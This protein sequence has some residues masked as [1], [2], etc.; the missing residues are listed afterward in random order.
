MF[1]QWRLRALRLTPMNEVRPVLQM[2]QGVFESGNFVIEMDRQ[3][4]GDAAR[5]HGS[6]TTWA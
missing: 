2:G 3:A 4:G 6:T 1:R 5:G